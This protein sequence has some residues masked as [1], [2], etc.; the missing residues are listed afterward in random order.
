MGGKYDNKEGNLKNICSPGFRDRREGVVL[1][2]II[3]Q[4]LGNSGYICSNRNAYIFTSGY[5]G[6]S[7]TQRGEA[8]SRLG[9]TNPYTASL[10]ARV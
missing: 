7:P 2:K 8:S 1:R 9:R 5:S 3:S 4:K 10:E 6:K